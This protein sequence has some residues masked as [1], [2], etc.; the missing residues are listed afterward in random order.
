MLY[1]T[2]HG[3]WPWYSVGGIFTQMCIEKAGVIG[4]HLAG[5][6]QWEGLGRQL[7]LGSQIGQK[8]KRHVFEQCLNI[9]RFS[10]QHFIINIFKHR[11][12]EIVREDPHTHYLDFISI[13]YIYHVYLS[14][15]LDVFYNELHR[16]KRHFQR[17][18][19]TGSED[20]WRN[21]ILNF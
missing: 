6:L 3:D 11:K 18:I 2:S 14:Y 9:D 15:F 16:F 7:R 20:C 19:S 4:S 13:N 8:R 1:I 10:S 12:V 21:R 17:C 5:W